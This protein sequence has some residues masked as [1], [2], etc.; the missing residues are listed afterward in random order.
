[1]T[2]PRRILV[3]KLRSLGDTV[4][5]TLS[6]A[7]LQAAFPQAQIDVLIPTPWLP[8]FNFIPSIH[9]IWTLPQSK[10]PPLKFFHEFKLGLQLRKQSYDWVIHLHASPSSALLA[11]FVGSTQRAIHFHGHRDPNRFSTVTI[12]NKGRLQPI[13]ERDLDTLRAFGLHIPTGQLP[14]LSIPPTAAAQAQKIYLEALRS[15][16]LGL[17]LGASRITK[18]WPI[19]KF[20]T[21]A[22]QWAREQH[23]SVFALAGPG[24]SA[25]TQNFLHTVDQQLEQQIQD[26]KERLQLRS[27]ITA[28]HAIP[29]QDLPPLLSC[30]PIFATNDSGPKHLAVAVGTP[31]VTLFGPEDPFEW[32]P[33][34]KETHP[35]AFIPHLACRTSAGPHLPPW[36]GIPICIT[37]KHQ[38]MERI[39]VKPVFELCRKTMKAVPK[40]TR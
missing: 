33:Y 24:E 23:G 13:I 11:R 38:C 26:P 34:P 14:R 4:L 29:L 36:C 5:M 37:E 31:T 2:H 10:H 7:E 15:P 22:I 9:Q 40:G 27:Q 35:I 25:L 6:L 1:M 21:L 8:L 30:F 12:P 17:G 16:I 19:D 20:A 39:E 32:H 28:T 3:I 18:I